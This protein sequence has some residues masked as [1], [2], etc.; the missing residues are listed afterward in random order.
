MTYLEKILLMMVSIN[1]FYKKLLH[2]KI[3]NDSDHQTRIKFSEL[4]LF[5]IAFYSAIYFSVTI[6]EGHNIPTQ[7]MGYFV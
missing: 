1:Q 4:G 3:E 5:F 6:H 7:F 2:N